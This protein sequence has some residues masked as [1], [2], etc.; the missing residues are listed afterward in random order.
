METKAMKQASPDPEGRESA[1]VRGWLQR[2]LHPDSAADEAS[3]ATAQVRGGEPAV[4]EPGLIL[5]LILV[6]L[7]LVGAG[8][9][10]YRYELLSG[11]VAA[12]VALAGIYPL[13]YLAYLGFAAEAHRK[14]LEDDFRLLGLAREEELEDTVASLYRTVYSPVQFIVYIGLAI[15]IS[16][17]VFWGYLRCGG[18]AEACL[19][20]VDQQTA[21]LAFYAYLGAYVFSVQELVRRYNTF[22]LQPQ[23]YSSA[24]VRMLIAVAIVFVA[25]SIILAEASKSVDPNAQA[26]WPAAVAFAIGIFPT[27]GLYWLAQ[28]GNRLIPPAQPERSQLPLGN[29]L[30]ISPWH[31]AR[32][33]QMGIDDAQNLATVDIRRL[34]LTTQFDTQ[35]I[36]SWVDQA[37][38]YVKVGDKLPR[39]REARIAS[40]HELMALLAQLSLDTPARL[41]PEEEKARTEGRER[42]AVALALTHADELDRLADDSNY[43]NYSHIA[44]YYERS[45]QVAHERATVGMGAVLGPIVK[46]LAMDVSTTVEDK[47]GLERHAADIERLLA[48]HRRD[49]RLWNTLGVA[50]YRLGRCRDAQGAFDRAIALDQDL[51][52]PYHH[53]SLVHMAEGRYDEAI[54]DCTLAIRINRAHAKAFNNRGLAYMKQ[55]HFG[56]AIEDLDEALRLNGRLPS[57]YL[58]RGVTYNALGRFTDASKDFERAYLL[59]DRAPEI[60]LPW[61]LALMGV[62]DYREALEKLS[63]AVIYDQE[64]ASA[65]ARRGYVY[66]VLGQYTEARLDLEAALKASSELSIARNNLGLVEARLGN[67]DAAIEHYKKVLEADPGQYVTRY[68]L[69][70]AFRRAGR[71]AEA[72]AEL[73]QVVADAPPESIEAREAQ[74]L[75]ALDCAEEPT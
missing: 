52:E 46:D 39:F 54:R 75:L 42:L 31:E 53:R 37:I 43:P 1:G 18:R 23:V 14:R 73:R 36:A 58:N 45:S 30:G 47:Q 20:G 11:E 38:L 17:V 61:G 32:L 12:F 7:V 65:R 74:D 40:Y 4:S 2:V 67:H 66:Y 8:L 26:I 68:N 10:A 48:R 16:L 72:C 28:L 25:A 41:P 22:D 15:L 56:L 13:T 19:P 3:G 49:A 35:E 51:V 59:D 34:L 70:L 21:R 9:Y 57:A 62:E 69:A 44:E 5:R 63:K 50:Y 55:G 64:P 60:W 29:L 6:V 24:V 27:Q 71:G 33:A